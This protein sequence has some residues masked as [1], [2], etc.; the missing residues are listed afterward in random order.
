MVFKFTLER[1]VSLRWVMWWELLAFPSWSDLLK[2]D[3]G[4][5]HEAGEVHWLH[6]RDSNWVFWIWYRCRKLSV[7]MKSLLMIL[8]KDSR[9]RL[10]CFFSHQTWVHMSKNDYGWKLIL[11]KNPKIKEF[12]QFS[13]R[14]LMQLGCSLR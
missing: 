13:P 5:S 2:A 10:I 8:L 14:C 12:L 11:L 1:V 4:P 6:G 9:K 3:A 7:L